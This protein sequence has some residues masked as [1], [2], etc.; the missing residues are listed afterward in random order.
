MKDSAPSPRR[1]QYLRDY[2]RRKR[3]IRLW[4]VC[5]LAGLF[6][7]WELTTRLGL[8][9]GFLTSSPSRM[10]GTLQSLWHSGDLWRHIG[11]SCLETVVGFTAGTLLGTAIAVAMWWWEKLARVLNPYLVVLNALPKTALGP[12]FIVWM[13]AGMGAIIVMTLAI[14]LIVT[15]LTM[16]QGFLGPQTRRSCGSCALWGQAEPDAVA[17]GVSRQL[18]YPL[19]HPE[20]KCGSVVGG[21]HY[22]RSFSFPVQGWAI[23]SSTGRRCSTWIW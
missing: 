4:Q 9:D 12:I 15:I 5:L 13:G 8:S 16:Y 11:T 3:S 10:A 19:Q 18:P 14:S 22:G 2:R 23:S 17:A 7:L 21:R 6:A 20:G 1:P